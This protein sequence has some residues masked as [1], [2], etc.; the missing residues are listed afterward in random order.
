MNHT[1]VGKNFKPNNDPEDS[2]TPP[3][4]TSDEV[5]LSDI[6]KRDLRW[7]EELQKRGFTKRIGVEIQTVLNRDIL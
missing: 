1:T 5:E 3:W 4:D 7:I 2:G 6:Q